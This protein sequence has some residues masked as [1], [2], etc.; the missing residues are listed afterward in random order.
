[1]RWG[2]VDAREITVA[3]GFEPHGLP[4]AAGAGVENADGFRLPVLF[5][6]RDV[7]VRWRVFGAHGEGVRAGLQQARDVELKRR[8]AALVA[9]RQ[10]AVDPHH[11]AIIDG[12]EMQ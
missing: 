9:S 5:A 3:R 6:A 2:D 8:V 12:A 10:Q 1:E 4:D 11:G 7:A